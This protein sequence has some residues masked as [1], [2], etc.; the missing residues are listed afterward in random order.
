MIKSRIISIFSQTWCELWFEIDL[1]GHYS[2]EFL[3]LVLFEKPDPVVV[4]LL[5]ICQKMR[6][7]WQMIGLLSI[8]HSVKTKGKK[9]PGR[10]GEW[11]ESSGHFYGRL[12]AAQGIR[13]LSYTGGSGAN[14]LNTSQPIT[15][16][17][18]NGACWLPFCDV[19][20]TNITAKMVVQVHQPWSVERFQGCK[21]QIDV[22]L[23]ISITVSWVY[24]LL[25]L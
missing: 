13:G 23:T 19:A 16:V 2:R 4:V 12:R 6:K 7:R 25:Y 9:T 10:R 17:L 18:A 8:N 20:P 14:G 21:S 3:L 1:G 5:I 15:S 11:T 24:L 22:D